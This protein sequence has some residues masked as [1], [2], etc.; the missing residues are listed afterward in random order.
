MLTRP[1]RIIGWALLLAAACSAPLDGSIAQATTQNTTFTVSVT[2]QASC[3]ISANTM[4]FGNQGVLAASVQQTSQITVDCTNTTPYT[5]G[6][7]NGQNFSGGTRRMKETIAGTTFV[8]YG[9]YTDAAHTNAWTT[10]TSTTT[11]TGGANTCA[12]GTGTGSAQPPITVYGLIPA[13]TTPA[14]GTF[15]DTVTATVTY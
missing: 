15:Q 11:C 1:K 14:P 4:A 5:V 6:L 2:I 12:I 8:N 3:T 9:L 7:D 13:Q 10:T